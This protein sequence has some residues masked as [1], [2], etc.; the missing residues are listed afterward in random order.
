MRSFP[1]WF[2]LLVVGGAACAPAPRSGGL[3][4]LAP[5][6]GDRAALLPFDNLTDRP[7]ASRWYTQVLG[8]RIAGDGMLDLAPPSEVD[9][10]LNDL[11]VRRTD[12]MD[13]VAIGELGRALGVR[14]LLAGSVLDLR[15]GDP[16]R[17]SGSEVTVTLRMISLPEGRTIWTCI[18]ARSG[19]DGEGPFGWG[20]TASGQKLAVESANAVVE[21]LYKYLHH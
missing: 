18:D 10:A 6:R 3:A 13:S 20:R 5:T 15:D 7:E 17:G 4:A 11:R 1:L 12:R 9:R 8:D 21:E 19:A 16:Y 2:L 14:Y